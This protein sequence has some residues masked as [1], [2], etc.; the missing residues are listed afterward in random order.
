MIK[1]NL[2]NIY[3]PISISEDFIEIIFH[4][5]IENDEDIPLYIRF[6]SIND[7]HLP[8]VYNLGFGPIDKDGNID[9]L[10]RLRHKNLNKLFSTLVFFCH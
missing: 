9:D 3:E 1:I 7:I 2:E 6:S 10:I 5:E 4:S 8:N